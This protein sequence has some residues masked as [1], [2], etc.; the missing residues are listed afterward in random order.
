MS[1]ITARRMTA[2][3]Q[4]K[5]AAGQAM[6][7][8]IPRIETAVIRRFQERTPYGLFVPPLRRKPTLPLASASLTTVR[9][10]SFQ[11][12]ATRWQC[13]TGKPMRN[14]SVLPRSRALIR[15]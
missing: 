7:I 12:L 8:S 11:A 4:F 3:V 15:G 14:A 10:S 9:R 5:T 13:H 2:V 6:A 1:G